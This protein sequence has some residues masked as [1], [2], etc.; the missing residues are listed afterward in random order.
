M[1][2]ADLEAPD[3][4]IVEMINIGEKIL[5]A[6]IPWINEMIAK[7]KAGN[8]KNVNTPAGRTAHILAGEALNKLQDQKLEL[9][10]KYFAQLLEKG[11]IAE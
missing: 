1:K 3:V 6:T 11:F 2:K 10:D 8:E 4:D 5:D 9:H 7:I